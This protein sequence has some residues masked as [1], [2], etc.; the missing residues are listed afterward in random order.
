MDP[1][2]PYQGPENFSEQK[3]EEEEKV[4]PEHKEEELSPEVIE[5]ILEKVLDINQ[6]GTAYTFVSS[7]RFNTLPLSDFP[8]KYLPEEVLEESALPYAAKLKSIFSHGLLGRPTREGYEVPSGKT[9]QEY[10]KETVQ[11]KKGLIHFNIIGRTEEGFKE[12]SRKR[13]FHWLGSAEEQKRKRFS[14]NTAV[15]FDLS[16]FEEDMPTPGFHDPVDMRSKTFRP[17]ESYN[18]PEKQLTRDEKGRPM[19]EA[20][21][22]FVAAFRIRPARFKGIAVDISGAEKYASSDWGQKLI[23]KITSAMREG[24]RDNHYLVP[25]YDQD[26]NLLWPKQMSYEEVKKFVVE[27]DKLKEEKATN[28]E[29]T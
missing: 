10:W 11:A 15:L 5:Q 18:Q 26:G 29:K 2:K 24:V 21:W 3:P 14:F 22:G 9:P 17:V 20:E 19:P 25:V 27:R 12:V 28:K 6:E 13:L 8:E 1:E 16:G 7:I 4:T 23:S